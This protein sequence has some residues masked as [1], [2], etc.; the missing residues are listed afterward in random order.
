M[1]GR[2]SRSRSRNGSGGGSWALL[3]VVA[4]AVG[5]VVSGFVVAPSVAFTTGSVDRGTTAPVA[6]DAAGFLGI[7]VADSLQAGTDGRLVTV[8]NNLNRTLRVDVSASVTLSKS[9]ATLDPGDSLTTTATVGCESPPSELSMTIAATA[10]GQFSGLATRSV[11]VDTSDCAASTL[12]FGTVEIVDQTTSAKGGKAE[13]AVSYSIANETDSFDRIE[14]DFE[15]RDRSNG[16]ETIASGS[17][18][19]T[20]T[21]E[22]GGRRDGERFEITVRL[23]DTTRELQSERIVVTDTA[24][25]GG[26]VYRAP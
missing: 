14:V 24:D 10:N 6:D 9:Q 2:R 21:F 26:I 22:S 19:G 25:G 4:I 7:D 18:S 15:N 13:Y 8:T 11:T 23:F 20:I 5:L 12:A 17:Q 3:A 16:V 1:I